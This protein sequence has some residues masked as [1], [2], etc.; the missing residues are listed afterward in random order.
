[1]D[2]PPSTNGDNGPTDL[3]HAGG[4]IATRDDKSRFLPGNP[5]GPGNPH[6]RNVAAW[7]TALADSVS[8]DDISQ[9]MERLIDAAKAGKAW[10]IRELLDRCLGKPSVQIDVQATTEQRRE[11][12]ERERIEAKRITAF[13]LSQGPAQL[14]G[15]DEDAAGE[16]LSPPQWVGV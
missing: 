2:T 10:A 6:V 3:A 16:A 7:R 9:V 5:G 13:L 12:T 4:A 11:Y 1:M 8:V 15:P 14:D